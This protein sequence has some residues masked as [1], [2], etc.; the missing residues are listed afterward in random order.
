MER[1]VSFWS[2]SKDLFLR[3]D[4][5]KRFGQRGGLHHSVHRAG[6][7]PWVRCRAKWPSSHA[8]TC[9]PWA[10]TQHLSNR[11]FWR[12]VTSQK[13]RFSILRDRFW[14]T[15]SSKKA[16]QFPTLMGPKAKL[17]GF[18][19]FLHQSKLNPSGLPSL[20]LI[21]LTSAPAMS[22]W[23]L[24]VKHPQN[25]SAWLSTGSILDA[26]GTSWDLMKTRSQKN[27]WHR[28]ES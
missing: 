21:G 15:L 13:N 25:T 19:N 24:W 9:G 12:K 26:S 1:I 8:A 20:S 2:H 18:K 27:Y 23:V 4:L 11:D 3:P 22:Q 6:S 7:S 14:A 10:T 5:S 28:K 17:G 16:Q